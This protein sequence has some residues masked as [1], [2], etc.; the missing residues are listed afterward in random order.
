MGDGEVLSAG[1]LGA[2]RAPSLGNSQPW[3]WVVSDSALWLFADRRHQLVADDPAGQQLMLSCGI[4]LHHAAVAISAAGWRPE[5]RRFPDPADPD[6]LATVRLAGP[7]P[8]T[9]VDRELLLAMQ[10][11]H[12]D[13]RPVDS[14]P[15]ADGVL[16]QLRASV[17]AGCW[18][19]VLRA[20]QVVDLAARADYAHIGRVAGGDGAGWDRGDGS[21]NHGTGGGH[22][23][24]G[25]RADVLA[26]Q[27][28]AAEGVPGRDILWRAGAGGWPA[29]ALVRQTAVYTLLYGAGNAAE[30]WFVGGEAASALWLTAT[31]LNL[32]VLPISD[33]VED[34]A[35]RVELRQILAGTGWPYLLFRFGH[36]APYGDISRTPRRPAEET[37]HH[38]ID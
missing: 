19:H 3:R 14:T 15:L 23:E 25:L 1:A 18:L 33:V 9:G 37:I 11:R 24:R 20:E 13:R 10:R 5:V 22:A 21:A 28:T 7:R 4:A 32:S 16:D 38:V 36:A 6:H 35:T 31:V 26:N 29:P 34:P 12:T 8:V 27:P 2:L 17:I 30:D